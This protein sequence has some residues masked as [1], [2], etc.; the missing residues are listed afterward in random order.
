V[1]HPAGV[2]V[3]PSGY[4]DEICFCARSANFPNRTQR[5]TDRRR[6]KPPPVAYLPPV[7][8]LFRPITTGS[9]AC[10]VS[11]E[12]AGVWAK[13]VDANLASHVPSKAWI[14]LYA[15]FNTAKA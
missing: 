12:R 15:R 11:G 9:Q 5:R 7:E 2:V 1:Y 4:P 3:D 8:T 6:K 13:S 14:S 10:P